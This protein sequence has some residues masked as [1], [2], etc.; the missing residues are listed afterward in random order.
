MSEPIYDK[1]M[2]ALEKRFPNLAELVIKKRESTRGEKNLS[3]ELKLQIYMERSW[4]DEA[5]IS[6]SDKNSDNKRIQYLSG[7]R[8]PHE[9]AKRIIEQWGKLNRTTPIFVTG[10]GNIAM[11]REL[12]VLTDPEINIMVYEPSIEIF[13]FLLENVDISDYFDNRALGLVIEGINETEMD[14]VIRSYI[15]LAN[16]E[17]LKNYT[18]RGY[19]ALFPEQVV[20]F[21]KRLDKLSSDIVVARNTG[22]AFSAVEADNIFHNIGYMCDGYITTQLCDVLPTDIPAIIV[23]AGPSLNKNIMELRKAKNKAFIVAVDTA[24]KPLVNAGII[25]DLYVIVDGLKPIDLFDFEEAKKIPL[26][27]SISSA[28]KV[29][30]QHTGKKFFYYEGIMLAYN[31]MAMNGIPFSSVAC[32]GSVACSAFSLVYKLGFSTIILVGQDLALTGNRTHADGTFKEK[33]DEIDTSRCLMVE[34]NY[35]EKVPTRGDFKRYLDWFNYYIEGCKGVHV[36]NATEGGAKIQNTE[37]MTLADAVERECRKSV[38]IQACM[39]RLT[40]ALDEDARERAIAYLN[41]IP[42]MFRKLRKEVKKEKENYKKLRK[43]CKKTVIDRS[44]YLHILNRIKKTTPA[45]E[46]HELYSMIS[47]SLPVAEYMISS[48]QFYEEDSVQAEGLEIARKG[49][50]YM[51]LV[52]QCIGLLIPLAENTVGKLT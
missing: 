1:N 31:I 16:I 44:A 50:K 5:V 17:F 36:I 19:A 22:I 43:I 10:M 8:K 42:D 2:A 48:E 4:D 46:K 27:P 35:E 41:T 38:D 30:S 28:S 3:E 34:G 29:L 20:Y 14:G 49:I 47:S 26:M 21:L 39:D 32:G 51:E 6:V 15:S 9:T 13:Y 7:K 52:D 37:I 25:P 11:I 45:I 23:S 33:M 18:N 24:V 40:P 12:L